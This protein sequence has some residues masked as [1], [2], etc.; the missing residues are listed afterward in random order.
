MKRL[1]T[2]LLTLAALTAANAQSR[3]G[4]EVQKARAEHV[5]SR[6]KMAYYTQ[7]FDLGGLPDYVPQ[8]EV[9]GT[10]RLWGNNYIED[11]NLGADWERE[12]R[13]FHP[14]VKFDRSGLKSGLVA[15]AGLVAGVADIVGN[16]RI[17]FAEVESFERMFN[18]EP[19]EI[20]MARGSYDVPGWMTTFCIVVHR[21]NPITKLTLKQL[22]GIFGA[23]RDGGWEGTSWHPE[24]GRGAKEN[25]RTWGQLGLTG[26]WADKPINVYGLNLR[27]NNCDMFEHVVFHG[28]DKWN[29]NL[30][31]YANYARA[32]GTLAIAAAELIK[33]LGH[34]RY[35]IGWSGIQNVTPQTKALALAATD[36]GPYVALT[37]E[38]VQ[39]RTYPLAF[40]MFFYVNRAP[41][42][43]LDPKV[44]EFLRF[45]LS[46][47]GQEAVQ[48]DG[49]Y[50]PLTAE[51]VREQL[52]KLE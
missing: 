16:R 35:G 12:F 46:R 9:T 21:D 51:V 52:K 10:I 14:A 1:L 7:K 22:D 29:E 25:I 36:G 8:Q 44:K 39:N 13:K 18:Y 4:L 20:T 3:D 30:R 33:D 19:L 45:V 40:D 47:Q 50:L 5:T 31:E 6:G 23:A 27:Y 26:E 38:N 42:Q 34:D 32:D 24:A 41:G 11:S 2:L 17:T 15:T 28:G 43:P 49:K 48:R 37:I